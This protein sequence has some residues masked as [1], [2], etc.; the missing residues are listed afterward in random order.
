MAGVDRGLGAAA[1][2]AFV[3]AFRERLERR[4][5]LLT[6]EVIAVI[7]VGLFLGRACS[8][9][10]LGSRLRT[11]GFAVKPDPA[12][13][14]GAAGLRPVGAL[15]FHQATL[16]AIPAAFLAIWWVL[17]PLVNLRYLVWR[18]PY[19]GLLAL[20][21]AIEIAAFVIPMLT[22]HEIMRERKR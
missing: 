17:I 8:Y 16:L 6:E 15:F 2:A 22:F 19:A 18:T 10:R 4:I 7:P 9:G 1:G 13:L 14:D 20:V 5:P 12:H 11:L 3:L 21:V